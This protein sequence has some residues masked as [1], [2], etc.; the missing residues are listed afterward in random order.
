MEQ[1]DLIHRQH[2]LLLR[3]FVAGHRAFQQTHHGTIPGKN[4]RSIEALEQQAAGFE[5]TLTVRF[6]PFGLYF[7]EFF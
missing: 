2:L 6:H 3:L 1:L 4:A 7:S 5:E